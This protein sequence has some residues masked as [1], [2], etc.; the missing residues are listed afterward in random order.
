MGTLS[1]LTRPIEHWR[2]LAICQNFWKTK[3]R[4]IP[5]NYL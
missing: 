4:T 3:T 1:G 2:A 5:T